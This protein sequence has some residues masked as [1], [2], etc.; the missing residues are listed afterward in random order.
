MNKLKIDKSLKKEYNSAKRKVFL[1]NQKS[2]RLGGFLIDDDEKLNK[3]ITLLF[4]IIIPLLTTPFFFFLNPLERTMTYMGNNGYRFVF[5]TWGFCT[6]TL[7]SLFVVR[8]F[9]TYKFKDTLAK[10]FVRLAYLFLIICVI[11]PS[12]ST[13]PIC[14]KIHNTMVILFA[15]FINLAL[16]FFLLHVY[17]KNKSKGIVCFSLFALML[18]FPLISL[19]IFGVTGLFEILF[20]LGMT[21]YLSFLSFY[22]KRKA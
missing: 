22:L 6:A 13:L 21:A 1:E 18:S 10:N 5:L 3:K 20:F 9:N 2:E 16:F 4:V 8:L 17:F 12:L 19:C 7:L 15:I 14:S 11:T